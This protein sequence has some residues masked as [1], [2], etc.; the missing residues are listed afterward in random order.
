MIRSATPSDAPRLADLWRA[1]G[2]RYHPELA[3]LELAAALSQDLT[4]PP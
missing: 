4:L 2:L 3:E 1:V